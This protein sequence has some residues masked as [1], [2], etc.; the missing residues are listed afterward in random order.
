MKIIR[1]KNDKYRKA[2]GGYSRFLEIHCEK[3]NAAI[4]IYQ[5][6]GPGLL[7]RM[8]IERIA[9]PEY[10]SKLRHIPIQKVPKLACPRCKQ[11]IGIP[12]IYA[13]EKRPTFRLFEGS[14]TKRVIRMNRRKPR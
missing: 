7:K 12:Y 3:C 1:L 10:F 11:L 13:K 6:D 9:S 14:V 2:R 8:Y 5:K 4:A